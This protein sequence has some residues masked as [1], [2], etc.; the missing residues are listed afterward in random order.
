VRVEVVSEGGEAPP[1][2]AP[3]HVQIL[4]TTYADAPARVVAETTA[5]VEHDRGGEPHAVDIDA[6]LT[7]NA[8]YR[9]RAHVDVDGDGA[10]GP[11]DFVTTAAH[12]ARA[13]E[14]VRVVVKK[15]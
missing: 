11:G 2:G 15:V 5:N 6:D 4:D 3:L 13:G 1:I 14:P 12:P 9:V 10:V 7:G 8:D